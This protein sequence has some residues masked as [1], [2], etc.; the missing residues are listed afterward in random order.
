MASSAGAPQSNPGDSTPLVAADL[1]ISA[2]DK[3]SVRILVVDDERTLRESC[4]SVLEVDGYRV[5][6]CGRGGEALDLVR[7][8]TFDVV[9]VDLY[10][11]EVSGME[12][13]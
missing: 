10:M 1:S 4:K 11:T 6:T 7:R 13:L 5:E 3:T 2:A 9:L 8:G 12:L